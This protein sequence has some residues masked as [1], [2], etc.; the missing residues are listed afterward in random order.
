VLVL[1]SF[2]QAVGY[3]DGGEM[4]APRVGVVIPIWNHQEDTLE[5]LTSLQAVAYPDVHIFVVDNGSTDGS[6][7]VV[8]TQFPSVDLS[9]LKEN[10]GF[11]RATNVG[12]RRALDSDAQYVLLLNNDT[13]VAPDMISALVDAAQGLP[14][15]GILT[16]RIMYY[17]GDHIWSMGSRLRPVTFD[18]PDF[19]RSRRPGFSLETLVPVDVILGCGM[20]VKRCVFEQVGLLDERFFFYYEDLDFSLRARQAGYELWAVPW[21]R[22]WHKVSTSIKQN[23]YLRAYY[24][25]SSSV[26]FYAKHAIGKTRW[27][28]MFY[29]MMS[30]LRFTL[31]YGVQGN[32][33]AL[34]GYWSGLRAGLANIRNAEVNLS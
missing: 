34:K 26:Y 30:A 10:Q 27:F 14:R 4:T 22:M 18:M 29:R 25:A 2:A 28:T 5:C 19:G 11:A 16:P 32:F 20:L 21:A 7:D 3:Q 8:M 23:H 6:A 1:G 31:E 17:G 24:M 12:I 33:E 15:G 13:V 9:I